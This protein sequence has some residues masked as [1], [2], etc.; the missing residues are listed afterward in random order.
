[1]SAIT[2]IIHL[3][4]MVTLVIATPAFA[5]DKITDKFKI[6]VGSYVITRYDSSMSLTDRGIG[7][8]LSIVPEETLGWNLEQS[9]L[10]VDGQYR[11]SGI[12]SLT[13]SWYRITSNGDN[14]LLN[15]IEW[16]DDNGDTITIPTGATVNSRFEYDIYKIGYLWSFYNSDKVKLDAGGGFHVTRLAVS[17]N[18]DTTSSGIE[19]RDVK[20][21]VPL[22]VLSFGLTYKVTPKFNWHLKSEYF[23]L[24]FEDWNG[25][26]ADNILGLDYRFADHVSVGM[27]FG[28]NTLAII[29]SGSDEKFKFENRVTGLYVNLAS[30]F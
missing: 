29:E 28:G 25:V 22:P 17:L 15:D 9:V 12:H 13:Y 5:N 7:A 6:A 19:A 10:R 1:M 4:V 16:V 3:F 14:V 2:W 20:T 11:F 8:G 21:T 23:R 18:S 24:A 30:H 26:Y 27:G